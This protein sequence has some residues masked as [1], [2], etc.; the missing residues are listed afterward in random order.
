[1]PEAISSAMMKRMIAAALLMLWAQAGWCAELMPR[2]VD[3]LTGNELLTQC[4][5]GSDSHLTSTAGGLGCLGYVAAASDTHDIWVFWGHLPRQ[6]CIP[7]GVTAVQLAQVS[8]KFLKEHPEELHNSASSLLL[9]ALK[10]AF[11]CQ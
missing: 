11:P 2:T 9:H 7:N 3:F 4:G 5:D 8:V 10:K 1:M 6:M